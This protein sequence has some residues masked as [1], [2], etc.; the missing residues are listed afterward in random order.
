M[1]VSGKL[2]K[3]CEKHQFKYF[4]PKWALSA[5]SASRFALPSF[6]KVSL[7]LGVQS[8]SIIWE[9]VSLHKQTEADVRI[10]FQKKEDAV[11]R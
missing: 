7:V 9:L 11:K 6:T 2:K 4:N 8:G 1:Q 3:K 5:L 10:Y